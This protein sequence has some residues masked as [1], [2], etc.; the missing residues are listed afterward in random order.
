MRRKL[1]LIIRSDDHVGEPLGAVFLAP[2]ELAESLIEKLGE[3]MGAR[4]KVLKAVLTKDRMEVEVESLELREESDRLVET[5]ARLCKNRLGKSAESALRDALQLDPL[6]GRAMKMLAEVLMAQDR[7]ADA[8]GML[9]RTREVSGDSADLLAGMAA[10]CIKLGRT[11]S[12]VKYLKFSLELDPKHFGARRMLIGLGHKPPG[13]P[14]N[15]GSPPK[16]NLK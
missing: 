10:C 1:S 4:V 9:V 13:R 11:A 5:A 15:G 14:K 12:A 7:P 3:Y 8:F 2:E 16:L 6:N